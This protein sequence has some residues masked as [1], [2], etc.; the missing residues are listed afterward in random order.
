M[1][2]LANEQD[3]CGERRHARPNDAL[4]E[5]VI[6]LPLNLTLQGL[7]VLVG[8]D[9]DRWRRR[10]RMDAVIKRSWRRQVCGLGEDIHEIS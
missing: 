5:H 3:R 4:A 7:R 10:Q 2:F 8:L 6:T 9:S 1:I